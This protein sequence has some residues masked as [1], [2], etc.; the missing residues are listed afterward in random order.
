MNHS[1]GLV[2][3]PQQVFNNLPE[4][5]PCCISFEFSIAQHYL[6]QGDKRVLRVLCLLTNE[7]CALTI[8]P[9]CEFSIGNAAPAATF[10]AALE[11]W[12]V[13]S[14]NL[15]QPWLLQTIGI[16]KPWGTEIWYTGI[17]ARGICTVNGIPLPWLG[18]CLNESI[19]GN[20]AEKD[21]HQDP[22][23]LKILATRPEQDYGDLYF[24]VHQEKTEVYIVTDIDHTVWPSGIGQIRVGFNPHKQKEYSS[25]EEFKT[26]YLGAVTS[27][28]KIRNQIDQRLDEKKLAAGFSLSEPVAT[29]QLEQWQLSLPDSMIRSEAT[30]KQQMYAFTAMQSLRPGDVIRIEPFT[31]HSLQHGIRVV[32]FQTA[33]YER[34]ILSFTQKVLTQ[35][36]WDTQQGLKNVR[37]T[38]QESSALK[39]TAE[40][41]QNTVELAAEF[42]QFSVYRITLP[43][44][45]IYT[46]NL[47]QYS[48]VI[49]ITGQIIVN[50]ASV[51][52]EQGYFIPAAASQPVTFKNLSNQTGIVLFAV[53]SST[54]ISS[55]TITSTTKSTDHQH[56]PN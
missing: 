31:P 27:Y 46:H 3:N 49:G 10:A 12:Q 56:S 34:H 5:R 36:H 50:D 2:D 1:F 25:V 21:R 33:H 20:C 44:E 15:N 22:I 18:L 4:T 41:S 40:S 28:Q 17:E 29:H 19:Y 51:T 32:E 24:E 23:L 16:D 43:V 45:G 30:L 39:V 38:P 11:L 35:N 13:K 52:S 55:T 14:V 53:P 37:L 9:G 47:S 26:A 54:A 8:V 6:S 48:L 7:D 42:D